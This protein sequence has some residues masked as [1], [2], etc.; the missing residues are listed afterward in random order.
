[1]GL[2]AVF[3]DVAEAIIDAF[4]DVPKTIYFHSLGTLT[5]SAATDAETEAGAIALTSKTD[6]SMVAT[7]SL[8]SVTTNLSTYNIP[9]DDVQWFKISGFTLSTNNGYFRATLATASTVTLSQKTVESEAAGDPITIIGP[10]YK[11]KG[12]FAKFSWK[13]LQD[14]PIKPN[15]YKLII[16][17][18]DLAITPKPRDYLL[19]NDIQYDVVDITKD[20]ADATWT[21]W[22]RRH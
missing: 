20:P 11:L 1:M 19:E 2:Q 17:Q 22:I 8:K 15:D 9:T 6:L 4:D 14:L 18:N 7:T 16:A 3:Q 13:E 10:F 5:Y 12:V 21:M